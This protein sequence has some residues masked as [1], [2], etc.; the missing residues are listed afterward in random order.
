MSEEEKIRAQI[1]ALER[2][3]RIVAIIRTVL[4]QHRTN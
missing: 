2:M 4:R 1:A 3:A